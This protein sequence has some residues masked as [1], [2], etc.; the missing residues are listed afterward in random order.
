MTRPARTI[1]TLFLLFAAGVPVAASPRDDKP[2]P[3]L[4]IGKDTT[5]V[6]GPLDKDGYIDYEAALNERLGKG[7]TPEKNAC[8]ALWAAIGPKP[9]GGT[10]GMP[11]A[12]FKTLGIAEPPAE[13]KYFVDQER[14]IRD[15]KLDDE[16]RT[17][18]HEQFYSRATERPWSA[19]E[20]PHVAAWLAAN[21]RA[22][23]AVEEAA[24]RPAFFQP[25]CSHRGTD[26][27]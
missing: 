12:Y 11:P 15:L 23:A 8:A 5:V 17:T 1:L 19:N 22:L 7:I 24:K 6:D 27:S 25:A 16:E 3:K 9:D 4:P 13:G 26:P 20:F 18:V 14:Y 10:R 2:K 21:E